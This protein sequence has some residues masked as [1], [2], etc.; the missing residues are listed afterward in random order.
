MKRSRGVEELLKWKPG[1]APH[2]RVFTGDLAI[3][4]DRAA[5]D[6]D[7]DF[8]FFIEG[9]ASVAHFMGDG[10]LLEPAHM[11]R[12]FS[13]YL[14]TSRLLQASHSMSIRESIGRVIRGMVSEQGLWI[15]SG[16][17]AA[18]ETIRTK[19]REKILRALSIAFIIQD[20]VWDEKLE[21]VRAIKYRIPE[22]SVVSLGEDPGALFVPARQFTVTTEAEKQRLR[23]IF[24]GTD[25]EGESRRVAPARSQLPRALAARMVLAAMH[26]SDVGAAVAKTAGRLV[27]P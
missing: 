10:I 1:D 14:D 25:D 5:E 15:R 6:G 21:V 26:G 16:I 22:I 24:V 13:A 18:E 20:A 2:V 4:H 7:A 9:T 27:R 23:Q 8:D 12:A 19:I 11:P 17:S 3:K